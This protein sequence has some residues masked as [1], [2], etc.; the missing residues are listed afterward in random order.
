[1]RE[2]KMSSNR[3]IRVCEILAFI[4]I[5]ALTFYLMEA[6]E[7]NPFAEVRAEA[8]LFNILLF[9]L[10]AWI[11]YFVTNRMHWALRIEL[12]LA[13]VFGLVNHY[14]VQF[15]ST[16]FVPWDIYSIGTAASVAG[17]YDF[18]PGTR[19]IVVTVV[20]VLLMICVGIF[21]R[22]HEWQKAKNSEDEGKKPFRPYYRWPMVVLFTGVLCLFTNLLQNEQFQI[23]HYLYP[24]LFTPAYMTEVNG[25]AVTFAMNLAYIAVDKPDGYDEKEA[26]QILSSY[27]EA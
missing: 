12:A 15:R 1:M 10:L 13:M 27:C 26:E 5:P 14:V 22:S 21:R 6:Y 2:K 9:E 20:F 23:R 16:P 11:L 25:M 3:L 19:V 4:L 24:F 7:H 8:Q 17:N 18:T